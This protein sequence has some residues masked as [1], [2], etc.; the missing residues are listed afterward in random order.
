MFRLSYPRTARGARSQS[1]FIEPSCE[2]SFSLGSL[3]LRPSTKY[4]NNFMMHLTSKKMRLT[5]MINR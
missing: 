5:E 4:K 1:G 3:N 2:K